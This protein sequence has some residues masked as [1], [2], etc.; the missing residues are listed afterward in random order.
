MAPKGTK[1]KREHFG[2]SGGSFAPPTHSVFAFGALAKGIEFSFYN[3]FRLLVATV[4][5]KETH[6]AAPL[7]GFQT[8]A[9]TF[10]SL[11]SDHD[12]SLFSR[13]PL[14]GNHCW[15]GQHSIFPFFF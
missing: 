9:S 3:G 6:P 13:W 5:V 14:G 12:P 1:K 7:E 11:A 2:S 15:V 8:V 4:V 10:D